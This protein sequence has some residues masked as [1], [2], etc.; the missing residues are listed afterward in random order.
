[1]NRG[2]TKKQ[3]ARV[4]ATEETDGAMDAVVRAFWSRTKPTRA[5]VL[6]PD[7]APVAK[8]VDLRQ[9]ALGARTPPST[10]RGRQSIS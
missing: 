10:T 5:K 1:M 4:L 2:A 8:V 3:L 6:P 7:R 9:W